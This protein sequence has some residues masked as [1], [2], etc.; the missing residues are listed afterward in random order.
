MRA[1]WQLE[2]REASDLSCGTR[3][4]VTMTRSRSAREMAVRDVS[5]GSTEVC[6]GP[7]FGAPGAHLAR[8]TNRNRLGEAVSNGP[9][10]TRT[11]DQPIMSRLRAADRMTPREDVPD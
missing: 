7:N 9:A 11:R 2:L 1:A 10:W 4:V 5:R 8:I 6:T 3:P